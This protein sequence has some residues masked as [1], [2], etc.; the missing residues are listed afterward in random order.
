M[1]TE[2]PSSPSEV[3]LS[4]PPS[5]PSPPL[6]LK[7]AKSIIS[8]MENVLSDCWT[9]EDQTANFNFSALKQC[10]GFE[11]LSGEFE[12]AMSAL[13]NSMSEV[14]S[15]IDKIKKHLEEAEKA[16]KRR[17]HLQ[18]PQE[19]PFMRGWV[20]RENRQRVKMEHPDMGPSKI[21]AELSKQWRQMSKEDQLKFNG[22]Q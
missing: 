2:T 19:R 14:T 5:P 8:D 10:P 12:T 6:S 11:E 16:E 1:D 21:A 7:D 4:S 20:R 9:F 22:T 15:I 3:L 13:S 17:K 18:Q